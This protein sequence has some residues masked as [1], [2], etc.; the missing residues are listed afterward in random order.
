MSKYELIDYDRLL[1]RIG[2]PDQQ[3]WRCGNNQP[4]VWS[5]EQ[6]NLSYDD[7]YAT[8]DSTLGQPFGAKYNG[9]ATQSV[10][11]LCLGGDINLNGL[12]LNHRDGNG[13][14]WLCTEIEGWWTLPPSEISDVPKPYWDG[15]MLTTGRYLMRTITVSGCF[16]P[17]D[18][19]LVWYNRDLLMRVGSIVR[20]IGLLAV[21]GNADYDSNPDISTSGITGDDPRYFDPFYDPPKMA[22]IQTNDVPLVETLRTDGF[23][24]FSLSFRCVQ[25]TKQSLGERAQTVPAGL[26]NP[27]DPH[28]PTMIRYRKYLAFSRHTAIGGETG[29]INEPEGMGVTSYNELKATPLGARTYSNVQLYDPSNK[30]ED[31]DYI[32]GVDENSD[33]ITAAPL[34]NQ[35][36]L[37]LV[38]KGNYFAFPVYVFDPMIWDPAAAPNERYLDIYNN[39]TGEGMRIVKEIPNTMQLVVDTGARRVALVKPADPATS[40]VWNARNYLSLTSSWVTLAAGPNEMFVS[41]RVIFK[42]NMPK[43][44]WRDTWIG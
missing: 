26:S 6:A 11:G 31:E 42:G 43:A 4:D 18:P 12:L 41:G 9:R 23:T 7:I 5:Y 35:D 28:S 14:I 17:P 34:D 8:P 3:N 25:P 37:M 32:L 2:I 38:N 33:T 40:W 30:I 24:Q 20:G 21:C 1:Y 13:T 27:S 22:M 39:V 16:V 10:A 36:D 44:Y 29:G 19:S 15:S